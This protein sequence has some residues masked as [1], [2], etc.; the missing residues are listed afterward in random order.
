MKTFLKLLTMTL[1]LC[2]LLTVFAGAKTVEKTYVIEELDVALN[3]PEDLTVL[4]GDELDDGLY[5]EFVNADYKTSKNLFL[6]AVSVR[7]P[8]LTESGIFEYSRHYEDRAKKDLKYLLRLYERLYDYVTPWDTDMD[9]DVY[10]NDQT[11]FVEYVLKTKDSKGKTVWFTTYTTDVAGE[12]YVFSFMTKGQREQKAIETIMDSVRV[13]QSTWSP[14]GF[15]DVAGHWAEAAITK[16]VEKELFSGSTKTTFAPDAPMTRAMLVQVL[17]RMEGE[18]KVKEY[19]DF[20]DVDEDDWYAKAV[21]WAAK[22]EIVTGSDGKFDPDG[23]LTRE[24]LAA[25]LWRYAKYDKRDVSVGENTNIL[26]Y[27]DAFDIA[28]YAI[29]AFQW[30]CG[31]GVM[32]G[33]DLSHLAPQATTT[34]AEVATILVRYLSK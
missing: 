2:T 31:S 6:G 4:E 9:V 14:S 11:D 30:T 34:R 28:H 12:T 23:L 13:A 21:S 7:E 1:V 33:V 32:K 15:S 18:P 20:S 17:Y 5:L 26:S 22:K 8:V 25:I 3:L 19:A 10:E 29:P 16:A 24:Q 27:E